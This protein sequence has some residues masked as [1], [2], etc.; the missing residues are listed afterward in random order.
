LGSIKQLHI[1]NIALE[2]LK[3]FPN[4]FNK[5]FQHNKKKVEELTDVNS[6]FVRNQIAGYITRYLSISKEGV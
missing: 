1:K 4:Q 2:L 6:K 3:R 5:D